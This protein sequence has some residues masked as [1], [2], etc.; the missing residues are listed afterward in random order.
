MWTDTPAKA[1]PLKQR[2]APSRSA[3]PAAA[4]ALCAELQ[5]SPCTDE[6]FKV[7]PAKEEEQLSL[8]LRRGAG[9]GAVHA[10]GVTAP[11][12]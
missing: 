2:L 1:F 8:A 7:S 10:P 11:A 4:S 3:A 12:V 9:E 6:I 5:I